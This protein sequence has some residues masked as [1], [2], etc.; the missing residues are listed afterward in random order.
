MEEIR[1]QEN[2][3]QE[4]EVLSVKRRVGEVRKPMAT[5][6]TRATSGRNKT[7]EK[8][9]EEG[10][11]EKYVAGRESGKAPPC[12]VRVEKESGERESIRKEIVGDMERAVER[13]FGKCMAEIEKWRE[14]CGTKRG[15]GRGQNGRRREKDWREG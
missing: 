4:L 13:M 6:A 5:L 7:K 2:L 15:R 1:R 9:E 8:K 10:T 3:G 14:E 11:M 12:V